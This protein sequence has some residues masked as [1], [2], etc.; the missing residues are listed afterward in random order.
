MIAPDTMPCRRCRGCGR[1]DLPQELQAT[2]DL[3]R[4]GALTAGAVAKIF[5]DRTPTAANNRL[6]RLRELGFVIRMQAG[7]NMVYEAVRR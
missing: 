4:A 7:R 1:V 2:L 6:E 5:R 3:V